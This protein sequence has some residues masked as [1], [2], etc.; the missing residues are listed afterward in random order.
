MGGVSLRQRCV[1]VLTRRF[2]PLDPPEDSPLLLESRDTST[3]VN[4]ELVTHGYLL[5]S[6]G[7]SKASTPLGSV[8]VR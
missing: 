8:P 1:M 6:R 5:R 7:N 2:S 3:E 4:Q